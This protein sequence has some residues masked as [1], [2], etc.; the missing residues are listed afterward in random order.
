M[1]NDKDLSAENEL[2]KRPVAYPSIMSISE[3]ASYLT[4]SKYFLYMLV[5][6]G[7]IPYAKIGKRIIFRQ[8]DLYDWIGQNLIIP[9][10]SIISE[11]QDDNKQ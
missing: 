10:H 3:A 8:Q 6:G 4:I 7:C 9:E 11:V 1:K 2:I 5:K